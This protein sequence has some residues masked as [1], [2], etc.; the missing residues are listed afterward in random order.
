ME[1]FHARVERICKLQRL[2][3]VVGLADQVLVIVYCPSRI[4]CQVPARADDFN[5]F[6]RHHDFGR[7]WGRLVHAADRVDG[8]VKRDNG[9]DEDEEVQ[10]FLHNRGFFVGSLPS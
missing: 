5:D 10:G 6:G 4:G 7:L 1:V 9:E 2:K 3:F 8:Q